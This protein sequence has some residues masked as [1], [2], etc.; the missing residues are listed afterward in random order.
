VPDFSEKIKSLK[1]GEQAFEDKAE[2]ESANK[3]E[4]RTT[5]HSARIEAELKKITKK[6]TTNNLFDL[7]IS[8]EQPFNSFH[9]LFN[10]EEFFDKPL[11]YYLQNEMYEVCAQLKKIKFG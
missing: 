9:P 1:G 5:S 2:D 3:S 7:T 10:D 4:N 11:D 8:G 6:Q